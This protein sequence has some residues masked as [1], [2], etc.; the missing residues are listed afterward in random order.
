MSYNANLELAVG[1]NRQM[2][3]SAANLGSCPRSGSCGSKKVKLRVWKVEQTEAQTARLLFTALSLIF[4]FV[5][6]V[7]I[8][9]P[10]AITRVAHFLGRRDVFAHFPAQNICNQ[11]TARPIPPQGRMQLHGGQTSA[12]VELNLA[13][14]RSTSRF[15]WL[16]FYSPAVLC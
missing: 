10:A 9:P 14:C 4:L 8:K 6:S 15:L 5:V 2:L 1:A 12:A 3:P 13:V 16:C 7:Q 11:A